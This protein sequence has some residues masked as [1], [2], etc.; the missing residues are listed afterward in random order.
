MRFPN[1]THN[2][3]CTKKYRKCP[4]TKFNMDLATALMVHSPTLVRIQTRL[5]PLLPIYFSLGS[6]SV[7]Y[8]SY[9]NSHLPKS[10]II[11]YYLARLWLFPTKTSNYSFTKWSI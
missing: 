8:Y 11:M 3:Q 5:F 4:K 7:H 10:L 1:R 2:I 9:I 6:P